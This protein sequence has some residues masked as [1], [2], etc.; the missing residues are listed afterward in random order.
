[1][2]QTCMCGYCG[3]FVLDTD[4]SC[5]SCNNVFIKP[6]QYTTANATDKPLIEKE[7]KE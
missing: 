6:I 5:H 1:M 4:R 7:E 2:S 3:A